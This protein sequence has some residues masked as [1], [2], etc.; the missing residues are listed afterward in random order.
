GDGTHRSRLGWFIRTPSAQTPVAPIGTQGLPHTEYGHATRHKAGAREDV[1]IVF[2][3]CLDAIFI[4][5][6]V[7]RRLPAKG[8]IGSRGTA[9]HQFYPS[10]GD[11]SDVVAHALEAGRSGHGLIKEQ[12]GGELIIVIEARIETAIE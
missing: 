9:Q 1:F 8:V 4:E 6:Q 2:T 5:V 11:R 7:K 10:V 3:K 12:V